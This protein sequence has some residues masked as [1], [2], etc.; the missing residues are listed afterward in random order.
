MNYRDFFSAL[1]R[2]PHFYLYLLSGVLQIIRASEVLTHGCDVAVNVIALF[3]CT[4]AYF[5]AT[6]WEPP[7]RMWTDEERAKRK[8]ANVPMEV[9]PSDS[10]K[11]MEKLGGE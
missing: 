9:S 3:F 2:Q 10:G 1:Q 11:I 8:L 7:R 4:F 6:K 5:L